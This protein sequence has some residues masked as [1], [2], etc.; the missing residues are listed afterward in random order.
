MAIP[1]FG[2]H[3][4]WGA[5]DAL[6]STGR[7]SREFGDAEVGEEQVGTIGVIFAQADEEVTGFDILV[8]HLLIMGVLQRLGSLLE[9]GSD[10]GR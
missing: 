8:Q 7:G 3:V 10:L 5:P 9:Q 6:A 2:S 1:L 4:D